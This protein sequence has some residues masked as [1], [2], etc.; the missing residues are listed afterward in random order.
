M[1]D[2]WFFRNICQAEKKR[3][4]T[5]VS[6]KK[7]S[8]PTMF[9][10]VERMKSFVLLPERREWRG[11]LSISVSSMR[12]CVQK[13]VWTV[14][15]VQTPRWWSNG[16]VCL[17][18]MAFVW[19]VCENGWSFSTLWNCHKSFFMACRFVPVNSI[20]FFNIYTF[21]CPHRRNW[22]RLSFLE[23]HFLGLTSW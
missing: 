9:Y 21:V 15:Q 2:A 14:C 17:C 11:H 23:R 16:G 18:L 22:R 4:E 6:R 1:A 8:E 13:W 19:V 20:T 5:I 3:G 12:H 10:C 7:K